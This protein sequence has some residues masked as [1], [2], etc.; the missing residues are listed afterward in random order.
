MRDLIKFIKKHKKIIPI[1][2]IIS[3]GF[4]LRAY[5][6]TDFMA[7][8]EDQVRDLF[9]IKNHFESLQPILLG[10]KAS[11]GNFFLPPFW[12]YL[13]SL[14]FLFSKSPVAQAFLIVLFS[15]ATIAVFYIFLKRFFS[16]T[17]ALCGS[18]LL[19]VS[20]MAIEYGRFAWNPNPIPFFVVL[21]FFFLYS[22]IF[23]KKEWG[24]YFGVVASNL[25]LQLHYQGFIL[26]LFFFF[27]LLFSKKLSL[28]KLIIF[29]LINLV[30]LSPYIYYELTHR[31]QNLAGVI[32]FISKP[33]LAELK[34]FGIPFFI[35]YLIHDFVTFIG[36]TVSFN[37]TYLAFII[38]FLSCVYLFIPFHRVQ[39]RLIKYSYFF[40][41][42]LLYFYRNSLID[43][44]LL[45]LIPI[46]ILYF[47]IILERLPIKKP[48][49]FLAIALL[50][51]L[52]LVFSPAF[53]Y[54]KPIYPEIKR[55]TDAITVEKD[56]C[57]IYD[58]F[59][60]SYTDEKIKYL[61]TLS[62]NQPKTKRCGT[63]YYVCHLD[64]CRFDSHLLVDEKF[65]KCE[66]FDEG[67]KGLYCRINNG[68]IF[69]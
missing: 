3:L 14:V 65:I 61:V 44:Y 13:M 23:D 20:P 19:A 15:T 12:Y 10:P 32:A 5:R 27:V 21:L 40:S 18:L 57:L 28:K 35:K 37:N 6:L 11:V 33:Q 42:I 25:L 29:I 1:L 47:L 67:N 63:I 41:I 50:A 36:R 24:F 45:F 48:I 4:F 56:Y 54:T 66:K 34:F 69:Y 7:Y 51:L 22:Y 68:G 60:E 31:F 58:L 46:T 2:L 30:L 16:N 64:K 9:F 55:V 49:V 8:H 39:D 59:S 17:I 38:F 43:Y 62:K 26:F 53:K 52:N